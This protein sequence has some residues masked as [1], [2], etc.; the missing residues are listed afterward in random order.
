MEPPDRARAA[1]R[2]VKTD[3]TTLPVNAAPPSA[4][5]T[6]AVHPL[7]AVATPTAPD[8]AP[9]QNA[10]GA[11]R[12]A[13]LLRARRSEAAAAPAAAVP[14]SAAAAADVAAEADTTAACDEPEL[15]AEPSASASSHPT[16][17]SRPSTPTAK[18]ATAKANVDTASEHM[19]GDVDAAH[20]QPGSPASAAPVPPAD[21]PPTL[22]LVAPRPES[23]DAAS[24]RDDGNDATLTGDGQSA[25]WSETFGARSKAAVDA[26]GESI[27]APANDHAPPNA[28]ATFA[29]A[30]GDVLRAVEP[31]PSRSVRAGEPAA[32]IVAGAPG[33]VRDLAAPATPVA[34]ATPTDSPDFAAALGVQVSVL[35]RD[36]VQH[37]EL[38]LHP[39]ETGPV[40]IRIEI[41]GTT[42]RI[43]FGADLAATRHAIE[44]GLP[45]LA[46]ALRDAGLTLAGGGVSQH[47]GSRPRGDGDGAD[48]PR[49]QTPAATTSPTVTPVRAAQRRIAAGGVDLY[50]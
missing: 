50:A 49:P 40:S 31:S 20:D 38:H 41:D 36:G 29:S 18:R 27:L 39:V 25:A 21:R 13:E 7:A 3:V 23:R 22:A 17:A 44:Q 42:A 37:A 16:V 19:D 47:A 48:G 15:A 45:E 43:D 9:E 1:D 32:P 10:A 33:E 5:A 35:A 34:L 14:R 24:T 11:R 30:L 8:R 12:F 6:P 28:D 4:T 46:S 2:A 26:T